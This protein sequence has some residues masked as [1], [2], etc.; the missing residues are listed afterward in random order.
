MWLY[1][2]QIRIRS[3]LCRDLGRACQCS[4]IRMG[5]VISV[6][7]SLADT[8]GVKNPLRYRGYY[9]DVETKLYYLQSRFYDPKPAASSMRIPFLWPMMIT[10]RASICLRIVRIIL[11]CIPIRADAMLQLL[12]LQCKKNYTPQFFRQLLL[13]EHH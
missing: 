8:V 2:L 10:F 6:T 12:I 13:R 4:C 7:G 5:K 1:P 11:L 9:Y 3:Y